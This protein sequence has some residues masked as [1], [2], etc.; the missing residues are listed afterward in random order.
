MSH[1]AHVQR[2]TDVLQQIFRLVAAGT[3]D[4]AARL[5][6]RCQED[7]GFLLINKMPDN[8][9]VQ[10]SL[11]KMFFVAKDFQKAALVFENAG[12]KERAAILYEKADDYLTA[13]EM[14]CQANKYAK[15]AAMFEKAGQY[16]QA[17]KFFEQEG[18]LERAA[19]NFE[20]A[21]NN[22][23]A[24]RTY[25][26]LGKYEKAMEL[27]QKV[28]ERDNTFLAATVMIGR[29]LA[30]QGFHDLAIRKFQAVV[31]NQ[32]MTDE[33]ME[34][35]YELAILFQKLSR[36]DEARELFEKILT[37]K[38]G[39]KDVA[40]RLK[41]LNESGVKVVEVVEEAAVIE[42]AAEHVEDAPAADEAIVSMMDGIEFLKE[43]PLFEELSLQEIKLFWTRFEQVEV[44]AGTVIIEQEVPGEAFFL[45]TSGSV[46]VERTNQGRVDTL[47]TLGPGKFF[48]EMSLMDPDAV[49]S[50]RVKAADL[51]HLL[52]MPRPKFIEMMDTYD[53][54]AL[55]VYRAFT[56]TLMDRL[57]S[58]NAALTNFKAQK[59]QELAKLFGG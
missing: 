35:Y 38:F 10:T 7:V 57:R 18:L 36:L 54:L 31:Q 51:C 16:E 47:A 50:A 56:R 30:N 2:S 22:Y 17:A 11:A 49:T 40:D 5:Y 55:K 15:G 29:I 1:D 46:V 13:A 26:N 12:D 28:E 53:R 48:G 23:L 58:T 9:K 4:E 59:D 52:K 3:V 33:T 34:V 21:I 37:K 41:N 39:Y 24:G 19:A 44:P 8:K 27:L 20:K 25:F 43:T 42:D 14:Y 45:L 6:S 32:G